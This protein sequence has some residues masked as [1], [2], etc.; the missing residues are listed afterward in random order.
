MALITANR[1]SFWLRES[2]ASE[3]SQDIQQVR[4]DT[5]ADVCIV[6]GGY[7]G[8]WT[9]LRLMEKAPTMRIALVEADVCGAGASGR[10][11]GLALSWWPKLETLAERVGD[12]EAVR[13]A[14]ASEEAIAE[15]G[16]FCEREGID[17][18]YRQSG[19][20]WVATSPAQMNAWSSTVRACESRGVV[21]F[22]P[23]DREEL[24]FRTGS[25]A[26]LGG[27]FERSAATVQPALLVRGLRKVAIRRGVE[28]FERSPMIRLDRDR[29]VVHCPDGSVRAPVVILAT[30]AWLSGVPELRRAVLPLSSDVIATEP[31]PE[32]AD[33]SLWTGGECVSN[34]RLMVDYYRTT[35]DGRVVF[36]RGGGTLAFASRM[37]T[38]FDRNTPRQA[39]VQ[40]ALGRLVPFA[41][42]A[43]VSAMWSGAVDRSTDGL[44][45]FGTLPGRATVV[46]A[47]GFSGNGVAPSLLAGRILASMVLGSQDELSRCGLAAGVPGRF[48]LEPARY[49]GG[50]V[51][52]EA[53]RRKETREDDGLRVGLFTRRMAALAPSGFFKIGKEDG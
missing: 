36:G 19:W 52:R 20:F 44:P 9:A 4:G 30:N 28:I 2:L 13:L 12:D 37:G 3:S 29:G 22:V 10:N 5:E 31:I 34:S 7:T 25:P 53:V 16:A 40:A 32:L 51:V 47:A 24:T 49:F 11:G 18:H 26:A 41:S 45:F 50:L 35:R 21:P 46:Y 48:P 23:V 42:R 15:I 43:R 6:G 38:A 33:G 1:W 8:L 39:E 27:V 17:A 14:R